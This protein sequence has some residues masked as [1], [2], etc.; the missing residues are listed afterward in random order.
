MSTLSDAAY[1]ILR[2]AINVAREYQC[3]RLSAL[4]SRLTT[5]WPGKEAEIAEAIHFWANSV[6]EQHPNGVPRC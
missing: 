5:R 1:P 3:Q 2:D 4:K 6:Q